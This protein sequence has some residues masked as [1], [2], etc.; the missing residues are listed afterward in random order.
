MRNT[1][2]AIMDVQRKVKHPAI[3]WMAATLHGVVETS[4]AVFK[5]MLP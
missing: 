3:K 1:G 2:Q 5:F 4:G